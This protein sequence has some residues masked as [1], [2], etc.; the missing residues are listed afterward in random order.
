[1]VED[2]RVR[3]WRAALLLVVGLVSVPAMG[4][5]APQVFV[6]LDYQIV[7]GAVGC[8]DA[9]GFRNGVQRQLG[10]D[11]F[12]GQAD[13]RVAVQLSRTD[14]GYEGRIQ[15]TDAQ[16]RDVGQRR[17]TTRRPGC[18]EI[19]NNVAFAVAVQI[20]LLGAL[21]PPRPAPPISASPPPRAVAAPP[22]ATTAEATESTPVDRAVP[23]HREAPAPERSEAAPPPPEPVATVVTP[24]NPTAHATRPLRL[25]LGLGPSLALAVVPRP[26]ADGRLFIEAAAGWFSFELAFDATWPVRQQQTEA[27]GF[28]LHRYAV[29]G[30]ACGQARIF[31]ACVT[32]ILGRLQAKGAGVDMP[33]QPAGLGGQLGV[34]VFARHDLGGRYFAALRVEGLLMLSR[35]TVTVNELPAWTTPRLGALI[36][37]D[38]GARF[39]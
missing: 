11:P 29:G 14:V 12:R 15:W 22:P 16:G 4:H 7:P 38:V 32:G 6:S 24:V 18:A 10:Y 9:A 31:G 39:F 5:A 13:R 27:A 36:G 17:L 2:P 28:S 37:A 21:A 34:R 30:A 8:A 26:A 3:T 33:L 25:A 19:V 35:W 1:M 23:E 20:Q